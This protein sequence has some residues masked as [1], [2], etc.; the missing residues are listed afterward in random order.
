[1]YP[2]RPFWETG[3]SPL[4]VVTLTAA[5]DSLKC[6]LLHCAFQVLFSGDSSSVSTVPAE[7]GR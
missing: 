3:T 4:S 1:M 5:L 7:W 6:L 2:V